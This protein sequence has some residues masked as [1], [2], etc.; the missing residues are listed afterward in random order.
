MVM[1]QYKINLINGIIT[2]RSHFNFK[3]F[4]ALLDT[5][6]RYSLTVFLL[7]QVGF[8]IFTNDNDVDIVEA[9]KEKRLKFQRWL[10]EKEQY[11]IK[12]SPT[13]KVE[14]L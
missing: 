1:E 13:I 2:S 10:D 8:H 12:N 7:E 11:I 14:S 5:N 9:N 6:V 4:N 3:V